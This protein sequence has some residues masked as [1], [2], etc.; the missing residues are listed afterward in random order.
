M[1]SYMNISG[2]ARKLRFTYVNWILETGGMEREDDDDGGGGNGDG[3]GGDNNDDD[4]VPIKHH[5]DSRALHALYE[6]QEE[7]VRF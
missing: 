2:K 1:A 3:G 7:Q 5:F 4:L 6:R